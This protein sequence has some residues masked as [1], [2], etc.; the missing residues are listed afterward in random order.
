MLIDKELLFEFEAGLVPHD[1]DSSKIKAKVLGFGEIS[2]IFQIGEN[3]A[4]AFK[5]MPL[6]R[7]RESAEQYSRQYYDYCTYLKKAGLEL[8]GHGTAIVAVPG[9]PVVF[10]IAQEQLPKERF[11]HNILRTGT[12]DEVLILI[13]EVVKVI[14]K[15][16]AFNDRNRPEIELSLDAQLSNWVKM[17]A[18]LYYIDTSTPLFRKQGV[19][20]MDPEPL[21]KSSPSFLRWI[22]RLFFLK[23]VMNRYY[24]LRS[25][26]IDLTANLYKEQRPDLVPAVV[27][28][29]N[30]HL[31][32][33]ISPLT[34]KEINKYYRE[35]RLIWTLF[36]AFRRIDRWITTK[37]LRKRYEFILP[38][39]IKR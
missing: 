32:R 29:I 15:V 11:I 35:D 14:K 7:D 17:G 18:R 34:V 30:N 20:Q 2:S 28:I 16:W 8:P 31:P 12:A 25:V 1:P 21:L 19:E 13:E 37:L 24:D 27:G 23:D 39:K 36:L 26:Y 22:L 3:R 10:Y 33:D 5:R 38:G 9:R 6:F 4:A